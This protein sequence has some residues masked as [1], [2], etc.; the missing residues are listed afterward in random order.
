MESAVEFGG[1]LV[2]AKVIIQ[3]PAGE[4]LVAFAEG[5]ENAIGGR[6]A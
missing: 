1:G 2:P 4:A 5:G 6:I 3:V